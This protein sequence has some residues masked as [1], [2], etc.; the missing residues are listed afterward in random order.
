MF[1][2]FLIFVAIVQSQNY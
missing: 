1:V 2:K